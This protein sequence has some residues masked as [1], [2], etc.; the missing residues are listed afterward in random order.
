MNIHT[1]LLQFAFLYAPLVHCPTIEV[2]PGLYRGGDPKIKQIYALHDQG[3]KTIIS[4][5]THRQKK[6]ELLC[7]KLGMKWIQ[8][9]TG[10]FLTPTNKQFNEFR[11]IINDKKNLP[12]Y[13]SCEIDMDRTGVYLAAHRLVDLHW[14]P[15]QIR[16]EFREH[17]QKSW[18]PVFRKYE[19]VVLAYGAKW[20]KNKS[21]EI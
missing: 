1:F 6:K 14:T 20:Q 4:L 8:I 9:P 18:W 19:R 16:Q 12:C 2:E 13:F 17:H 11:Q 7:E 10:V 21:N 5:R 15:E 3:V